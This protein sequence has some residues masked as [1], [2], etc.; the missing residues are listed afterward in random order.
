[1]LAA[2]LKQSPAVSHTYLLVPILLLFALLIVAVLRVP[3]LIS[4]ANIGSAII[5][6]AP[7]LLAT[8]ALTI[9]A[10]AGRAGVDL[11]VGPMLGFINVS[12][13]QLFA[14]EVISTPVDFF[15]YAIAAGILYQ[16]LMGL[17]IV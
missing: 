11:S 8:Y 1:M 10:M 4:S 17:I 9:I 6:S 15:A 16:I 13:I 3:N 12:L 14:A 2:E 7:L 5:V